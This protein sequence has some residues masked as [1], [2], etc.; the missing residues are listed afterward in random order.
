MHY[1]HDAAVLES[2]G[3]LYLDD[4]GT[5]NAF[6]KGN[7]E[8]LHFT[9]KTDTML[10]HLRLAANT[11]AQYAVNKKEI[12]LVVHNIPKKPLQ[13]RFQK[14]ER[15]FVW[16]EKTKQL[17]VQLAWHTSKNEYIQITL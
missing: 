1:Y 6:E 2:K 13:V 14:K 7:Y 4:G 9:S 12:T 15:A 10:L 11:G 5:A 3:T 16:N 8:L 17:S